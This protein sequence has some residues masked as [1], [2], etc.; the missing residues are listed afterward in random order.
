MT[1]YFKM[2]VFEKLRGGEGGGGGGYV[3]NRVPAKTSSKPDSDL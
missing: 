2:A 1:N 3:E